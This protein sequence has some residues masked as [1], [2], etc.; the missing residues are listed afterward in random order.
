M[1][2]RSLI[3]GAVGFLALEREPPGSGAGTGGRSHRRGGRRDRDPAHRGRGGGAKPA[4]SDAPTAAAHGVRHAARSGDRLPPV[5]ER[6]RAPE[7]SAR[8]RPSSSPWPAPAPTFSGML[9]CGNQIEEGTTDG[10]AASARYEELK[11]SDEFVYDE[12][13]ARHILLASEEDAQAVIEELAGGADFAELATERSTGP[14]GPNGGDLGYFRESQM[15]PEFAAAA[16]AMEVGTSSETPVQDAVRLACH[17]G[18]GS[19][20]RR[21]ELRGLRSRSYGRTWRGRS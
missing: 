5:G 20:Q 19:A 11:Q 21:T 7:T 10:G 12:I 16:F 13:H 17:L 18:R 2:A 8:T 14:S 3:A 4:G 1:L 6:G 9:W 15:V